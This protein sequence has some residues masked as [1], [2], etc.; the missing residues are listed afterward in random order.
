MRP[1]LLAALPVLAAACSKPADSITLPPGFTATVF[2]DNLGHVR[3]IVVAAD[4]TVY[5][6]SLADRDQGPTGEAQ[7]GYLIA[8]R[9]THGT[10]RADQIVRFGPK[11]VDGSRGGTGIGLYADA[12]YA[13]A[14]MDDANGGAILRFDRKPGHLAPSGPPQTVL[15]GLPM[16]GD[17]PMHPFMIDA[18]GGLF[19]DLGSATNACQRRNRRPASPGLVPCQELATRAGV[20]RYSATMLHQ[21]FG[22]DA[23]YAT[24]IRNGEGFAADPEGR[25]FVTQHG[26]DQLHENWP[27]LFSRDQGQNL[28]AEELIALHQ[29]TDGGWPYCYFDGAHG[30][31]VLAPEYGGDGGKNADIC[32]GKQPP[33]A[34]FPAH[35]APNDAKYYAGTMFPPA[36]R[37]GIYIAFHGSWN[38]APGPQGGY[39]VVFQPMA[40]GEAAGPWKIFADGFAGGWKDPIHAEFRPTGLAIAADGAMFISDDQHGRIWRITASSAPPGK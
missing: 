33:I 2:A 4:G 37:N 10:G 36:W 26:R 13:E 29:G 3:Q 9:D 16:T 8:L 17:H 25:M 30:K 32:A 23:R 34:A 24:G 19:V 12:L 39:N 5:A 40:N 22:P 1:I 11:P 21:S 15:S 35:W 7:Q 38:R 6:N 27:G 20:W 28:P 31:L 18:Q 14:D